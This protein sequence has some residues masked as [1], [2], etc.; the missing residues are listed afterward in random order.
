MKSSILRE[1]RETTLE[2]GQTPFERN[3]REETQRT[4]KKD[5]GCKNDTMSNQ[6]NDVTKGLEKIKGGRNRK[7]LE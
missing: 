5:K 2:R 1:D 6:T 4:G 3:G 7:A